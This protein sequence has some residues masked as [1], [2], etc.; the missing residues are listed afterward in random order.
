ME[1]FQKKKYWAMKYLGLWYP[2]VQNLFWK[3]FKILRTPFH[4][5][6]ARSLTEKQ[7]NV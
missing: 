5:L 7:M 4:I 1:Y 6:D 3:I 2:G